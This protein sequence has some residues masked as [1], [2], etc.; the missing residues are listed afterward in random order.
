MQSALHREAFNR[1]RSG[2]W[3][4][5]NA[6]ELLSR[7][8]DIFDCPD[9]GAPLGVIAITD[10][11]AHPNLLLKTLAKRD[12]VIPRMDAD[13]T[14]VLVTHRVPLSGQ[15]I[16]EHML[17]TDP[18][19]GVWNVPRFVSVLRAERICEY[20]RRAVEQ[21]DPTWRPYGD[22]IGHQREDLALE[23]E[24]RGLPK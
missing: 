2:D 9:T 3:R 4:L 20:A 15:P 10:D 8:G 6:L 19:A 22:D 1:A 16:Q 23:L 18:D 13:A 17:E 14:R 12:E 11:G 24:A 5:S 7:A 21:L